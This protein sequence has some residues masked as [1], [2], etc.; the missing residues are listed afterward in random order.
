MYFLKTENTEDFY[1]LT[2][3]IDWHLWFFKKMFYFEMITD[4]QVV[5][6]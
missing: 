2:T 3:K 6:N 4:S 5:E 1:M